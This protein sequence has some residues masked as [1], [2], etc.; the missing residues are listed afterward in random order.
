MVAR[1]D[2]KYVS[3][4]PCLTVGMKAIFLW[5][6]ALVPLDIAWWVDPDLSSDIHI[7]LIGV[8]AI[9]VALCDALF[10]QVLANTRW[11]PFCACHP[12]NIAEKLVFKFRRYHN[13]LFL[14]WMLSK[15]CNSIAIILSALFAVQ[16]SSEILSQYHELCVVIGYVAL[17]I[18]VD[19]AAQFAITYHEALDESD[20]VKLKEMNYAYIKEHPELFSPN[21]EKMKQQVAGFGE[22]YNAPA[23]ES[24]LR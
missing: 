5:L 14:R 18:S 1:T 21:K 11:I 6:L 15:V 7:A 4:T 13:R 23:Q 12:P 20:S 19:V 24:T 17:G 9:C 8:I 16:K 22:G 10:G 2:W 3:S